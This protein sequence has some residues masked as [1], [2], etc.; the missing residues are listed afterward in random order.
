MKSWRNLTGWFHPP[1]QARLP[2]EDLRDLPADNHGWSLRLRLLL[3]VTLAL[4]PIAIASVVQGLDR[5]HSD[6]ADVHD[7]LVET[8]AA[9]AT[10][11]DNIFASAEQIARTLAALPEVRDATAGCDAD[12][13]NAQHGTEFTTNI[14]RTDRNGRIVCSAVPSGIGVDVSDRS[15][16][17]T[18]VHGRDFRLSEQIVSR[19]THNPV[20]LGMLP[21]Y[22][23]D[24]QFNGS[25]TV[26]LDLRWLE[27]MAHTRDLPKGSIAAVFD[28]DGNVIASNDKT[29]ATS[30]F[31]D[32]HRVA[33]PKSPLYSGTDAAGHSWTYAVTPM[34]RN[35]IFAGFAMRDRSLFGATYVHV[36]TDFFLPFLMLA[37]TWMAIWTVTERQITRWIIYLRRISGAYR[38][39]H[40]NVRPLLGDA[41]TEF[42]ALGEGL[43]EMASAIQDRDRAL[44]EAVA[45]KSVIIREIHHRV[46]NNLQVVMSLL[47]LQ[48]NQLKDPLAQDALRQA[49]ARINALAQVHRI[50]YEVEDKNTLDL[51]HMIEDM[52]TQTGEMFGGDRKDVS[53][54]LQLLSVEVSGDQ[55]VPLALFTVEALSNALK[56]AYPAGHHGGEI[57]VSLTPDGNECYRLAV[58]D[59]GAGFDVEPKSD[60]MGPRLMRTFAQQAGGRSSLRSAIGNGTEAEMVFAPKSAR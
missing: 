18:I 45:Q 4:A 30:I 47:S 7:R 43:A 25:V 23:K 46:K 32:R 21:I 42:R 35:N 50:L 15:I 41:P 17:K 20:I 56:H 34:L 58:K 14:S 28:R 39:G 36:G 13:A 38:T 1:I 55:A 54:V 27:Y 2:A 48:S 12:L 49:R 29:I 40:Y 31:R 44:R 59:D 51:K 8:A 26:A 10:R 57:H 6:M 53:V 52:A 24:G 37:L 11:E 19:I 16:W 60:N 22:T 33:S 3:A 9:A 5:A